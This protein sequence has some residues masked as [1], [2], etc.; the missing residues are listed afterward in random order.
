MSS[1]AT[2]AWYCA[3]GVN[4]ATAVTSPAA[5]IPGTEV[6]MVL[7]D[8]DPGLRRLDAGGL[9][10]ELLDV[11]HAAGREQDPLRRARSYGVRAVARRDRRDH[12]V[13]VLPHALHEDVR[14]DARSPRPRARPRA[15]A[16]ASASARGA[17]R[18][19]ASTI[20][21]CGAEARERLA[22]L[23]PDRAAADDEQ[24]LAAPRVSSSALTWSSQSTSSI[25]STGGTAVREP[26]AIRIRSASSSRSP[27]RT[28]CGVDE[29]RL[30][31]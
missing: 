17:I 19:T 9:E 28:V 13:A 15:S 7:V 29:R 23:E 26:V 11:R 18:S 2:R 8:D 25:P 20:V 21:T 30:A 6:R 16:A 3:I 24:R 27:T 14:S 12:L 4:C 5:Q 10:L 22:E 1:T 31:R